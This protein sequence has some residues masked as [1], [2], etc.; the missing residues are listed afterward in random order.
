VPVPV[1]PTPTPAQNE[2]TIPTATF[3]LNGKN[4]K[5]LSPE[6]AQH[7]F[8]K[9]VDHVVQGH[10]VPQKN[11]FEALNQEQE[12]KEGLNATLNA[13]SEICVSTAPQPPP[14]LP[15]K[16]LLQAKGS[17]K[18]PKKKAQ[19]RRSEPDPPK[20]QVV[21]LRKETVAIVEKVSFSK[22][23]RER[24]R[25]KVQAE[26]EAKAKEKRDGNFIVQLDQLERVV[27]TDIKPDEDA[28]KP[29]IGFLRAPP[30]SLDIDM[31]FLSLIQNF[32]YGS[33]M[34][35][36][37]FGAYET[38]EHGYTM[39]K[40]LK[41]RSLSVLHQMRQEKFSEMA[42]MAI[43]VQDKTMDSLTRP[44][45]YLTRLRAFFAE[46]H[47][48]DELVNFYLVELQMMRTIFQNRFFQWMQLFVKSESLVKYLKCSIVAVNYYVNL[49][50]WA[51]HSFTT[52]NC[53]IMASALES[54]SKE[55]IRVMN[56]RDPKW[57]LRGYGEFISL[58]SFYSE[59]CLRYC[60]CN[61]MY[62]SRNLFRVWKDRQKQMLSKQRPV[63][64]ESY[65]MDQFASFGHQHSLFL[66]LQA[67]GYIS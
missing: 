48:S 67:N 36:G 58:F 54:K 41:V 49:V 51:L 3:N 38:I 42:Q 2:A 52:P 5:S 22:R 40:H 34:L 47:L 29:F 46:T 43:D 28:H 32:L 45:L 14:P 61:E 57:S 56:I 6:K 55:W 15:P 25:R 12:D 17:K 24:R 9:I 21:V 64:C 1:T 31:N 4:F 53:K 13:T 37:L 19:E 33:F 63:D 65:I 39:T 66:L 35:T 27:R 50:S 7:L 23:K 30:C 8:R 11:Q 10:A 59:G 18:K 60:L 20:K 44:R 62:C 16:S 26:E